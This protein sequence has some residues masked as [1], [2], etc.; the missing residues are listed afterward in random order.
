M[1][2]LME[3]LGRE[4]QKALLAEGARLSQVREMRAPHPV[5]R[6]SRKALARGLHALADR[7]DS[8]EVARIH[9]A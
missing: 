4:R 1:R 7:V 9:S 5:S 3:E 8:L 6:R 2:P